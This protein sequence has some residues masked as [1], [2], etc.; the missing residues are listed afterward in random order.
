MRKKITLCVVTF[1]CVFANAQEQS[2]TLRLKW[3]HQFQFA[4]YY[5]AQLKGF[6]KAEGLKVNIITGDAVHPITKEVSEG[7]ADFG[8]SGSD[9][10]IEYAKGV[11]LVA[12]GA[13][14]Q[15]SP[16][17]V[18]TLDSSKIK[19]PADLIGKKIMASENQGW[20]E[21]KAVLLREGIS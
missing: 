1:M 14:F 11:P 10:L 4:G 19:T 21:L 7:R 18:M 2:V 20:V 17:V 16:Y 12:V 3:W 9:I 8:I 5:A 15:H 13:V 6:Y